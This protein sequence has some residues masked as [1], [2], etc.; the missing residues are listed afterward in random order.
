MA[1]SNEAGLMQ[2]QYFYRVSVLT[3]LPPLCVPGCVLWGK[4]VK[5]SRQSQKGHCT[6]TIFDLEGAEECRQMKIK[7]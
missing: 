6:Q 3:K 2:L 1:S 4:Y 5:I 7:H